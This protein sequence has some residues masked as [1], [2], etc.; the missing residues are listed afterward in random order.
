MTADAVLS[1]FG[2][3]T[4]S[5][6]SDALDRLGVNGQAYGLLPLSEGHRIVGR[7]FTVRYVPVGV[8]SGTVGDYVD[9]VGPDEVVVLDNAAR[10]DCTV[11]G[12][13][14][15]EV[16]TARGIRGTVIDGVCRDTA[17]AAALGYPIFSRGHW[18]RT[19]KDRVQAEAVQEAVTIGGVRTVPGDVV[20][21]DADGVVVVPRRLEAAVLEAAQRIEA[22]EE[23]IRRDVRA[24]A[25][26]VEARAAHGYH[27]LQRAEGG[28]RDG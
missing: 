3:V 17:H 26:L 25:A 28:S 5:A 10:T 8:E 20:V 22:V 1:G 24:G 11:W 18:M 6:V 13:I 12:D 14:L 7:A 21:G 19:G 4:T 9:D 23:A 15:T 2:A 27:L 16:A